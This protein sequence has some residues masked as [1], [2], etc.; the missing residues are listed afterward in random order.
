MNQNEKAISVVRNVSDDVV[1]NIFLSSVAKLTLSEGTAKQ[2][3]NEYECVACQ[4][5]Q[6]H[7]L[8][9]QS[10]LVHGHS[11]TVS[12]KHGEG[13]KDKPLNR[14]SRSLHRPKS[15]LSHTQNALII[16]CSLLYSTRNFG[17]NMHPKT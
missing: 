1:D 5:D 16:T 13:H 8:K 10:S 9:K 14:R 17:T 6:R 7:T 3:K 15:K 2:S 4:V 12:A 11:R